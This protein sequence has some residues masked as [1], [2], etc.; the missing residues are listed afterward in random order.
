[1]PSQAANFTARVDDQILSTVS[2]VFFKIF[3]Y[4]FGSFKAA[5]WM[6]PWHEM[7]WAGPPSVSDHLGY[8]SVVQIVDFLTC[9]DPE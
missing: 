1:M 8:H 2:G 9:A 5:K 3:F 7:L 6:F 4:F